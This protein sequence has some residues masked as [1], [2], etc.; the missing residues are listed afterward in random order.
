MNSKSFEELPDLSR[1]TIVQHNAH[2]SLHEPESVW[3]VEK[4]SVDL[5]AIEKVRGKAEGRRRF[6]HEFT[7][8]ALLFGFLPSEK[9]EVVAL[10]ETGSILKK[11][12]K[13]VLRKYLQ[14]HSALQQGFL[15]LFNAWVYAL[16]SPFTSLKK[17]HQARVYH[18][19]PTEKF[20]LKK[21]EKLAP[22]HFIGGR[23]SELIE[24]VAL[25]KGQLSL[26][27]WK[28]VSYH[29]LSYVPLG[30]SL[31][32]QAASETYLETVSDHDFLKEE[33]WLAALSQLHTLFLKALLISGQI[34]MHREKE[35]IQ[36]RAKLEE[37]SWHTSFSALTDV[38]QKEEVYLPKGVDPLLLACK[39]VG[40][41]LNI[42]FHEPS[43]QETSL[44]LIGHIKQIC[45]ASNARFRRVTLVGKWYKENGGPLVGFLGPA[46][47]PVALL[48]RDQG[49]Y[50]MIDPMTQKTLKVDESIASKIASS[51]FEF[52]GAFNQHMSRSQAVKFAFFS[53]G[54]NIIWVLLMGLMMSLLTLS[55]P[56]GSKLIYGTAIPQLNH[57]LLWQV[58]G[59]LF[60]AA[61]SAFV[62]QLAQGFLIFRINSLSGNRFEA[63]IW[64]RILR[65]PLRFFKLFSVGD[66]YNRINGFVSLRRSFNN[67]YVSA[68]LNALFSLIY[69]IAMFLFSVKLTLIVLLAIFLCVS[70]FYFCL[71]HVVDLQRD[72]FAIKGKLN[73]FILQVI[74]GITK[75]RATGGEKQAFS[76]WARLYAEA[77]RKD[78]KSQYYNTAIDAVF[79]MMPTLSSLLIFSLVIYWIVQT[80][81]GTALSSSLSLGDFFGF[82]TAFAIFSSAIFG[83]IPAINYLYRVVRPIW[84][85]GMVIFDQEPESG[86]QKKPFGILQGAVA[87]E[88]VFFRYDGKT[89]YLL[90][91]IS[92]KAEPGEFI[93][94][95]GPSGSGKSTLLRLLLRFETPETGTISYD[96]VDLAHLDVGSVRR[97]MGVVLQNASLLPGT[98]YDNLVHGGIYTNEQVDQALEL[99]AF[100]QDLWN[101]P[102]GLHTVLPSGGGTLSGGQKQR[103][104]I[105]RALISDPKIL[106]FDEATSQLDNRTQMQLSQNIEKLNVT[107]IV[108][109]HRLSTLRHSDRIYVLEKGEIVDQGTFDELA[110]RPGLFAQLVIRQKI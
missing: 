90:K 84:S 109:A 35:L 67:F 77:K 28:D 97:Q 40:H 80:K 13:N 3:L 7:E 101:F 72:S 29:S 78:L 68:V 98:I 42:D 85:R 44:N 49:S 22:E 30:N 47:I 50:T 19:S 74:S 99:S 17:E 4:G 106:L 55:L 58:G 81:N 14:E 93:G 32:W 12:D 104:L 37:H 34:H 43:Q 61:F 83:A 20:Y 86:P 6:I 25:T 107:R 56:F 1:Q 71:T 88:Q 94:I 63:A 100:K 59:A 110:A 64:D 65:L 27:D 38:L 39:V 75:L 108:I 26:F 54:K 21:D 60:A 89:P 62:Y 8:G 36:E 96:G 82:I 23:A 70:V 103:L 18:T 102:M 10:I 87:I 52:Y 45:E 51:A 69:L 73:G 92:L 79:A 91:N 9:D 105:A 11:I 57:N 16:Y 31:W 76:Y 46:R 95:V 15:P 24:W 41:E 33:L 48:S 66:L 5:F 2:F 53:R